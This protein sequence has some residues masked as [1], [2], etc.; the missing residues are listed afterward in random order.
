MSNRVAQE[1]RCPHFQSLSL[2]LSLNL[3]A[4]LPTHPPTPGQCSRRWLGGSPIKLVF[5]LAFGL[6]EGGLGDALLTD[7]QLRVLLDIVT[8]NLLQ[9]EVG[10]M[11][12]NGVWG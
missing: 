12:G 2:S 5:E 6:G 9:S 11:E 4:H 7:V 3:A 10:G 8:H 1:S